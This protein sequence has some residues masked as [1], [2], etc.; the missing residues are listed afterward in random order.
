M[1]P[2]ELAGASRRVRGVAGGMTRP[3]ARSQAGGWQVWIG[4]RVAP[5]ALVLV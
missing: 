1:V 5:E 4:G 3:I 2:S